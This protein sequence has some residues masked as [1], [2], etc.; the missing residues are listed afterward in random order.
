MQT[1][2]R[3]NFL[4]KYLKLLG[5]D[6]VKFTKS[7]LDIVYGTVIYDPNDPEEIQD[8]CWHMLEENVPSH[9]VIEIIDI[10]KTNNWIDV[11][12]VT[13]PWTEIFAKST[14]KNFNDFMLTVGALVDVRVRMIDDEEETDSYFVHD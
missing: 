1:S 5:A 14:E 9:K 8:F 7:E 10:I 6:Q 2:K 3:H 12:K 11:D 4:D 13:A